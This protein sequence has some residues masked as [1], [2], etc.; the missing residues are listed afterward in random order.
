MC[1]SL[2]DYG[3]DKQK[4]HDC[5]S[6]LS[7]KVHNTLTEGQLCAA[8]EWERKGEQREDDMSFVCGGNTALSLWQKDNWQSHIVLPSSFH[9][10]QHWIEPQ[11]FFFHCFPRSWMTYSISLRYLYIMYF[12]FCSPLLKSS[13]TTGLDEE[14]DTNVSIFPLN[15]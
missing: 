2:Q 6:L 9:Q 12:A 3:S 11:W 13:I 15:I 7:F 10:Q 8:A 14:I 5:R 1:F 4:I